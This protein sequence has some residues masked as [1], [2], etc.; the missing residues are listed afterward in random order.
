M[1]S[2]RCLGGDLASCPRMAKCQSFNPKSPLLILLLIRFLLLYMFLLQIRFLL[3]LLFLGL[4][5]APICSSQEQSPS[6]PNNPHLRFP[7]FLL[8]SSRSFQT[9]VRLSALLLICVSFCNRCC[10]TSRE[11]V[12][13]VAADFQLVVAPDLIRWRELLAEKKIGALQVLELI[14]PA[15]GRSSLQHSRR[16]RKV[17][18]VKLIST[19]D[20]KALG[21]NCQGMGRSL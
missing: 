9:R 4:S 8:I 19:H 5:I 21:W 15:V 7:N 17:Q 13:S 20:M 12:S 2:V 11:N 3:L 14:G 1:L 6:P 10:A 18:S 16:P